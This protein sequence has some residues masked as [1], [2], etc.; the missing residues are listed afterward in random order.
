[1]ECEGGPTT[2]SAAV[3][4]DTEPPRRYPPHPS[5]HA[6]RGVLTVPL[7][8]PEPTTADVPLPFGTMVALPPGVASV[9]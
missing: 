5:G 2:Q 9:W 4:T 6:Y 1:M 3:C 8:P 7:R